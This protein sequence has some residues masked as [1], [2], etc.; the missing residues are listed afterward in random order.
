MDRSPGKM[1]SAAEGLVGG[2]TV[3]PRTAVR[4]TKK[5]VVVV[6]GHSG[7]AGANAGAGR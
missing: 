4:R 6:C 2:T 3:V 5:T 1:Q 7:G